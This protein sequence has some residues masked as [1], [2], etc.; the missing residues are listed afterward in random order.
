[1]TLQPHS[2][3]RLDALAL[4]VFDIAASLREM[5][6][7]MRENEIESLNLHGNKPSEWLAK[8]TE[9]S[10]KNVAELQRELL[11]RKATRRAAATVVH[12][13]PDTKPRRKRKQAR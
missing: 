2:P 12:E 10:H 5:S 4:E 3:E 6:K 7:I 1:M 13:P 9:W 8:L 11:Q